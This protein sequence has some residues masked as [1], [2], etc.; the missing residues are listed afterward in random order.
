MNPME[1][2]IEKAGDYAFCRD[3]DFRYMNDIDSIA[4]VLAVGLFAFVALGVSLYAT[5][6]E[7]KIKN[8][9][10]AVKNKDFAEV[11]ALLGVK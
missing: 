5:Y 8:L 10:E 1:W 2:C 7:K 3:L 9:K 6:L 4:P 11:K